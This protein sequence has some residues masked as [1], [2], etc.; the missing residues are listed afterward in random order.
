[1]ISR[2]QIQRLIDRQANGTDVLSAFL[3]MSV[4]SN[5][6][7]THQIFLNKEKASFS[8]LDS[9]RE[10]HHHEELGAAFARLERWLESDYEE[11]KK[12]VAFYTSLDG[13]WVEGHQLS[14]PVP[15]R[16]SIGDR[17]IVAPQV[18]ILERYHH[19]GVV[20]VDREH[21]KLQSLFLDQ[22]MNQREVRTELAWLTGVREILE[23]R[24][25]HQGRLEFL[26]TTTARRAETRRILAGVAAAAPPAIRLD[27][28]RIERTDDVWTLALSGR[29]ESGTA[30]SAVEAVDALYRGI[31]ARL[32]AEELEFGELR[33]LQDSEGDTGI[34][35]GSA[36]VAIG[37]DMSFIVQWPTDSR[38]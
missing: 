38:R 27:T 24:R 3:D 23:S 8:E 10:G 35:A 17:P 18:E 31:P 21:L 16:L 14:V 4:N 37:F 32:P 11:S 33:D 26:E 1:M 28:L 15:N 12:G 30:A 2:E 13:S 34:A 5:N 25:A 6:K 36:P 19:H 9:D 20:I 22:T 29:A 7:R